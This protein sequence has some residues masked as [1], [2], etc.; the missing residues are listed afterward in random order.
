M[1]VTDGQ[2]AQMRRRRGRADPRKGAEFLECTIVLLPMLCMILVLMDIS[3]AV[4]VKSTI[5]YAVRTGLRYGI[6]VTGTQAGGTCLTALVKAR[7]QQ[8]SLGLLSGSVGLAHIKVNYYLPSGT[9][10]APTDVSAQTDG[11][12]PLNIMQVSV[13]NYFLAALAPRVFNW[14]T[15]SD[16]ASDKIY[17]ASADLIESSRDVPCIGVAP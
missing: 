13:Q 14:R 16:D 7:V 1:S 10:A 6:T 12:K 11:N 4:F 17:V 2:P 8:N 9:T 5:E 3:W 15:T